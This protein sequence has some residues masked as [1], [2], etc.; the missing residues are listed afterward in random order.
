MQLGEGTEDTKRRVTYRELL[1]DDPAQADRFR[2]VIEKLADPDVRLITT[3]KRIEPRK[4]EAK[5]SPGGADEDEG[6]VEVAHEALIRGWKQL[7]EW[8]DADRERRSV[9]SGA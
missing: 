5:E 9:R 1:P 8:V 7:R 3:D 4:D 6:G 2:E